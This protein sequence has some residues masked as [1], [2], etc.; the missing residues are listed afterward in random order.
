VARGREERDF[1]S[2]YEAEVWTVFGFFSYR[3][4]DKMQCQDLTQATFERALRA[5][6]R[7]DPAR[8]EPRTWLLA[9]ARNLLIDSFRRSARLEFR[10][11]LPDEVSVDEGFLTGGVEPDL[12][13]ALAVLSDR[14]RDVIA[15][16]FGGDM[17]SGEI[18]AV[19]TLSVAN[20]HQ[21]LSRALRKLRT[22]L[23]SERIP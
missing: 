6:P 8:A 14:E 23:E 19:L 11:E 21:I 2:V 16:R 12:E 20:V 10:P 5:W 4:R 17:T 22:E 1:A 9:I 7:F 18:A 3:L 13:R 15:L